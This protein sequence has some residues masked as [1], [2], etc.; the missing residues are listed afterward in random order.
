M[1]LIF[2]KLCIPLLFFIFFTFLLKKK[3]LYK[4]V[5]RIFLQLE[6]SDS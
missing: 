4:M 1:S 3:N 5:D 6:K 2:F